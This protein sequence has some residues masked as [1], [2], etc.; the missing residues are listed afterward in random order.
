MDQV[1]EQGTWLNSQL[2]FEIDS[3]SLMI[4]ISSLVNLNDLASLREIFLQ[5]FDYTMGAHPIWMVC[6]FLGCQNR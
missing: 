4:G 6:F 5:D 3:V 2:F 1:G